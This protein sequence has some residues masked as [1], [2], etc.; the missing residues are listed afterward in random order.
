MKKAK[1]VGVLSLAILLAGCGDV[2]NSTNSSTEAGASESSLSSVEESSSSSSSFEQLETNFDNVKESLTNAQRGRFELVYSLQGDELTDYYS[3][4]Y[5]LFASSKSGYILLDSY[6]ESDGKIV[7]YF[8]VDE[9]GKVEIQDIYPTGSYSSP[10]LTSLSSFNVLY[11]LNATHLKESDF[12][13]TKKGALKTTNDRILS[14]FST[15]LELEETYSSGYI[16]SVEFYYNDENG[17]VFTLTQP[18]MT[19]SSYKVDSLNRTGILN[20]IGDP[21]SKEVEDAKAKFS[22]SK[23]EISKDSLSLLT[24]K[25]FEANGKI[26]CTVEG[27]DSQ[28]G[29][30]SLKYTDSSIEVTNIIDGVREATHYTKGANNAIIQEGLS[31]ENKKITQTISGATW[32]QLAF[33]FTEI[34]EPGAFRKKSEGVYHYYGYH[35]DQIGGALTYLSYGSNATSIDFSVSNG[36]VNKAILKTSAIGQDTI[37]R[38]TVYRIEVDIA[39]NPSSPWE[40]QP[41]TTVDPTI[42]KAIDAITTE[43][44]TYKA[45]SHI[46]EQNKSYAETIVT[47]DTILLKYMLIGED[48]ST[49]YSYSGYHVLDNGKV[50][51]FVVD[52][53]GNVKT[54]KPPVDGDTLM[55]HTGWGCSPAVFELSSDQKSFS[56]I[57]EAT[58]FAPF[59]TAGFFSDFALDDTL[60][61]NLGDDGR[62]SSFSYTYNLSNLSRKQETI[63][64]VYDDVE[65]D[66]ALKAKIDAITEAGVPSN[67]L[68]ETSSPNEGATS[69]LKEYM[70]DVYGEEVAKAIPYVFDENLSGEWYF[71]AKAQDDDYNVISFQIYSGYAYGNESYWNSYISKLKEKLLAAGYSATGS[72]TIFKKDTVKI[73][74]GNSV[75]GITFERA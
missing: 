67:W 34:T 19:P 66:A 29:T 17:L 58:G 64:F 48:T 23:E 46:D 56:P 11:N 52:E 28:I 27:V 59:L 57:S 62:I 71:Q 14:A 40:V 49:L 53:D 32:D 36:L 50:Q 47:P 35:A 42:Q 69:K 8:S 72:N 51:S 10:Y 55:N 6:K 45:T 38:N 15:L 22:I 74:I 12:T 4:D 3:S 65:I 1:L 13:L 60:V 5:V 70:T 9:E 39:S 20:N 44:V 73:T 43:G 68:E 16:D 30:Y 63:E 21:F 54:E 41:I 61:F 31:P 24:A 33:G 37:G 25:N 75:N 2:N 7:Y 18:T 26:Y